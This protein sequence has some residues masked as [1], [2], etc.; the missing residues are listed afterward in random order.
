MNQH[1]VPA[2]PCAMMAVLIPPA[3]CKTGGKGICNLFQNRSNPVMSMYGSELKARFGDPIARPQVAN[4]DDY[5]PL[6]ERN[7]L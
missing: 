7:R 5:L 3:R 6:V 1:V 2:V 4:P